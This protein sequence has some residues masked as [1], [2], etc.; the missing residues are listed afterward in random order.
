MMIMIYPNLKVYG[1]SAE[2]AYLTDI[3]E[4]QKPT[5]CDQNNIS[6]KILEK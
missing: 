3:L 4:E 6:I 1:T 5:L 2:G